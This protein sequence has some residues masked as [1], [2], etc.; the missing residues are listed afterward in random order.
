MGCDRSLRVGITTTLAVTRVV[1]IKM[2]LLVPDNDLAIIQNGKERPM[3][4]IKAVN[5]LFERVRKRPMWETI[6]FI[7]DI[8]LKKHPEYKSK[9]SRNLKNDFGSNQSKDLRHLISVPPDL[10]DTIDFF[11]HDAIESDKKD[12]MR[13]FASRYKVFAVPEKI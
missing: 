13:R 10:Y 3:W 5:A 4:A 12:F 6:D 11:Y 9:L 7:V 8:F 1:C 2:E